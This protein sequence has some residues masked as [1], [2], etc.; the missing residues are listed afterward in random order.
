MMYSIKSLEITFATVVITM[1]LATL[2][3][4]SCNDDDNDEAGVTDVCGNTYKTLTFGTQTWMAENLRTTKYNDGSSIPNLIGNAEW[5]NDTP[6]YCW[7][8]NDYKEK[9]SISGALYN[10]YAVET[11]KLCPTGWHVPSI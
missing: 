5:S 6:A 7:Y 3:L 10:W 9:G 1:G 8:N 2:S 11:G 4:T